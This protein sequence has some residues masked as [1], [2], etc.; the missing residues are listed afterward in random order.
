MDVSAA[1]Q[2]LEA[3]DLGVW[4]RGSPIAYPLANLVHLLGLVMLIGGIGVV[5]LR[6]V[7]FGRR[8]SVALLARFLT[9]IAIVGIGILLASGFLLFAADAEP[10][11]KSSMFLQKMIL[12]AI[13]L[14]NAL[15]FQLLW[16]RKVA[17]WS[18]DPPMAARAM[19]FLSLALWLT[20]AALGR[21][22]AYA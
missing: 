5:D 8:I 16:Q 12:L 21:L 19:A 14:T 6:L 10:L 17:G 13:A 7:G 15:A 2:A 3:S 11:T 1:A 4:M 22:I 9:P 18:D 20:I